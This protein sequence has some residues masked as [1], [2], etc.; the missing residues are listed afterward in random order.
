V[1]VAPPRDGDAF[2]FSRTFLLDAVRAAA[3]EN[4]ALAF[5][6]RYA[7]SLTPAD[8]PDDVGLMMPIRLNN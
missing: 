8:R 6:E 7:L 5:D 4:I 1:G 3:A 2:G